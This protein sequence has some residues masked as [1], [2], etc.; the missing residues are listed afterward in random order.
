MMVAVARSEKVNGD[1]TALDPGTDDECACV[2]PT[3]SQDQFGTQGLLR[4]GLAEVLSVVQHAP[5]AVPLRGKFGGDRSRPLGIAT[6]KA[7]D[8]QGLTALMTER[9]STAGI[10]VELPD[11]GLSGQ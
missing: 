5:P 9:R 8:V 7:V 2:V 1:L 3:G 6:G 4:V 10:E 11:E